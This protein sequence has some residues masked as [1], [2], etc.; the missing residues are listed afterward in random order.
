[1]RIVYRAVDDLGEGVR[2]LLGVRGARPALVEEL[3]GEQGR[4][5]AAPRGVRPRRHLHALP[6]RTSARSHLRR[7]K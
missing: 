3:L 6:S 4:R 1:M 2:S 7:V 5:M